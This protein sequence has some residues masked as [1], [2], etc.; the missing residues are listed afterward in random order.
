MTDGTHLSTHRIQDAIELYSEEAANNT[1]SGIAAGLNLQG[2]AQHNNGTT[3]ALANDGAHR[4]SDE[5]VTFVMF[6]ERP[7]SLQLL[8]PIPVL[9]L[10]LALG[11]SLPLRPYSA[12]K[13]NLAY[14]K[15]R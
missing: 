15:S 11:P 12:G 5:M 7:W 13:R 3:A 14:V 9:A 4:N 6:Y 2:I 8:Q 1:C 10:A